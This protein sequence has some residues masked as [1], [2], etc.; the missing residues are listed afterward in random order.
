LFP[1]AQGKLGNSIVIT[2]ETGKNKMGAC[3]EYG[4]EEVCHKKLLNP[5]SCPNA[6]NIK[7]VFSEGKAKCGNKTELDGIIDRFY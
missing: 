1:D 6:I 3:R 4:P 5:K 2:E 7:Y